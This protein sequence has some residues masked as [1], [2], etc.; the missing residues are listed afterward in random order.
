LGPDR[1]SRE[2]TP[3]YEVYDGEKVVLFGH[4]PAPKPRRG[5]KAI[6][7]DTGCVYGRRLTAYIIETGKLESVPARRVYDPS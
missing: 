6:G 1:T 4:W 2:G 5:P 7:L 3:W